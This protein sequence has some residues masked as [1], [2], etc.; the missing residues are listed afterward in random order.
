MLSL[1]ASEQGEFVCKKYVTVRSEEKLA[2]L[3]LM[4]SPILSTSCPSWLYPTHLIDIAISVLITGANTGLGL[5]SALPKAGD[6]MLSL[7]LALQQ[8][9]ATPVARRTSALSQHWL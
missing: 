2:R 1:V 7:L 3:G 8:P 6:R 9:A 4:P 5:E